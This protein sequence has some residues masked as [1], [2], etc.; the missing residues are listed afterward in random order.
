MLFFDHKAFQFINHQRK[1]NRRHAT[2]VEFLQ[3]YNFTIKHKVGVQNFEID[4]L[5]KKH[6]VLT[7]MRV[8][9]MGFDV[10]KEMYNDDKRFSEF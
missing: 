9:V 5:N 2:W 6:S 10:L 7:S 1:L 8:N 3:A 4:A